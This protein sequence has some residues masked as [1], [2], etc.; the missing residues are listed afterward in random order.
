MYK[1]DIQGML[2][3]LDMNGAEGLDDSGIENLE[4]IILDCNDKMNK[5][6]NVQIADS[7]YDTLYSAL[8]QVKPES[9]VFSEIWDEEGDISDYNDLLLKNPMYSIETAKSYTCD[10]LI[11]FADRMPDIASYFA[12]YKLNGHGIRVVYLDGDLVL[13]TSR[14]RSSAGRDLTRQL[15]NILGDHNELL[16]QYGLVELRGEVVLKLCNLEKAREFVP[17]I[18]SAFS[19]VSSM[20]APSSTKE[21]NELL[22]FICYGFI[23][24]GGGFLTRN[25]EF[26]F[27]ESVGY[28]PPG[29]MYIESCARED[30]PDLFKS[31]VESFE[32]YYEEYGYFCDGVVLEVDSRELFE[33]MGTE[34]NHRLGNIALKVGVWEQICYSGVVNMILWTKGK[35]K[36]S[37]VAIVSD[38]YGDVICDEDGNPTNLNEIGV[39]TAQGNRC[40]RVPLYEPK[41]IMILDA[42]PGEVLS[43]RYGSEAGVVPCFPDG[44]LLKEDAAK[45]I[46]SEGWDSFMVGE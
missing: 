11:K 44:R 32:E 7:I 13:A 45:E 14:A 40:K 38:N 3:Y 42:Y 29:N 43:F 35:S 1:L 28:E 18:K 46:L 24:D 37:P 15:K 39:L 9:R 5:T 22:E 19:G 33:E 23:T 17:G 27:I 12:S 4:R 16:E 10:E 26:D 36:L 31:V 2:S 8:K 41:N 34:G 25:E 20:L 21:M 6:E 30:L